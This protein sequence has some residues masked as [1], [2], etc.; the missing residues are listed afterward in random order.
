ML[1]SSFT[2]SQ[3]PPQQEPDCSAVS[4]LFIC[5]RQ[6]RD[7]VSPGHLDTG[8]QAYREFQ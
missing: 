6:R 1:L 5:S 8:R 2:H 7:G 4:E 3:Q